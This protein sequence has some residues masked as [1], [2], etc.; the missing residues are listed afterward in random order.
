LIIA[1]GAFTNALDSILT[2]LEKR[3]V[4]VSGPKAKPTPSAADRL[5]TT[6]TVDPHMIRSKLVSYLNALDEIEAKWQSEYIRVEPLASRVA[7][8]AAQ[9]HP[10]SAAVI[11]DALESSDEAKKLA[12]VTRQELRTMLDLLDIGGLPSVHRK[13]HPNS[14]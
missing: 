2:V 10:E 3:A 11:N 7:I 1:L 9:L 6:T 4:G 13:N 14:Q 8:L 5:E 12:R